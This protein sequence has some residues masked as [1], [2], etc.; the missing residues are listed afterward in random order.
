MARS[1]ALALEPLLER[2]EGAE[3]GRVSQAMIARAELMVAG[4]LLVPG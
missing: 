1:T 4:V 2:L 3:C